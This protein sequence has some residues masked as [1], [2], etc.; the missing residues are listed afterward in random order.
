MTAQKLRRR[1]LLV[2]LAVLSWL[3]VGL[4]APILLNSISPRLPIDDASVV[5]AGFDTHVFHGSV[6]LDS[7]SGLVVDGGR[8]ALVG[9][10]GQSLTPEQVMTLF[11][12]G[13]GRLEITRGAIRI[14]AATAPKAVTTTEAS[15]PPIVR[16][17]RALA[18]EQLTIRD[19]SIELRLPDGRLE[20]LNATNIVVTPR[21]GNQLAAAGVANWRGRKVDIDALIG[22]AQGADGDRQLRISLKSALIETS[23]E[24]RLSRNGRLALNGQSQSFIADLRTFAR[25]LGIGWQPGAG[26]RDVKVTGKLNWVDS[27]IAFD[28]A[29]VELDGQHAEGALAIRTGGRRPLVSGTLDFAM[30][31]LARYLAPAKAE[32]TPAAADPSSWSASA[33]WSQLE[34][35]LRLPVAQTLDTDLRVSAK[36]LRFATRR[37]GRAAASLALRRGQLVAQIA[38]LEVGQGTGSGQITGN[39]NALYPRFALLGRLEKVDVAEIAS[40][41]L[42]RR[43][44]HG[45]GTVVFDLKSE[46]ATIDEL[47]RR[48]G[49]TLE[50]DMEPGARLSL[51]LSQ[52][53]SAPTGLD[54]SAQALLLRSAMRAT[55][56]LEALEARCSIAGAGVNCTRIEALAGDR[57]VTASGTYQTDQ[58]RY[59]GTVVI[60]RRPANSPSSTTAGTTSAASGAGPAQPSGASRVFM[61]NGDGTDGEATIV[62]DAITSPNVVPERPPPARTPHKRP[63][64]T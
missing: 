25:D 44:L 11:K 32:A 26:L 51:D 16:Q 42:P 63:D 20:Q 15:V 28:T 6:T 31:D 8:L 59:D 57:A 53:W 21:R 24:G 62:M 19:S 10:Q 43:P 7:A 47:M 14:G 54:T 34:A 52:L 58:G 33:L 45:T 27:T 48:L 1:P 29:K 50:I 18:F 9:R 61:L 2:A 3:A 37:F 23:F 22:A 38:E 39:F 41:L 13:G 12:S 56:A 49:G 35:L 60:T 30:L 46:G 36:E 17:L 55:T 64:G 40:S 5:A 4:S